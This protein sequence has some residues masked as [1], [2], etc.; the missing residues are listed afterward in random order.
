[1]LDD[2]LIRMTDVGVGAGFCLG[3]SSHL[4]SPSQGSKARAEA[5]RHPE[6]RVQNSHKVTQLYFVS[7]RKSQGQPRFQG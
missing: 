7:Q 6:V 5:A 2:G 3:F 1:M 4:T